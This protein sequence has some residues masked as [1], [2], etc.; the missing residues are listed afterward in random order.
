MLLLMEGFDTY[1]TGNWINKWSNQSGT[2]GAT[3]RNGTNGLRTTG[4][5]YLTHPLVANK[6]ELVVGFAFKISANKSWELV[7]F[8]DGS[9]VQLGVN[10]DAT[11]QILI[12]RHTATIKS[13]GYNVLLNTWYYIEFKGK[14]H[15]SLGEWEVHINGGYVDSGVGDTQQT[16]L[17]AATNVN[18]PFWAF[19]SG[20]A[21]IDDIYIF[22]T[23]G[24]VN[25]DFVGDVSVEAVF[26]DGVGYVTDWVGVPGGGANYDKV[27]ELD[28]DDDTTFVVTSGVGKMD[29]YDF[30]TLAALSGSVYAL[31]VNIW[32]RKDDVGDRQINAIV[33]PTS[34]TY[35][36]DVPKALGEA[37]GYFTFQFDT[38]P[39]TAGYWTIAQVNA[40]EFGI[41][42][43]V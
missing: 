20:T 27:D 2:I 37:Y 26:P 34:T 42:Q 3:G 23:E 17:A 21:D 41:K 24:S 1:G 22:D 14:I 7:Q 16:G 35:S 9:T 6:Q 15:Q 10:L 40:S 19:G 38:N 28:P 12:K 29:S 13:T 5:F 11:G 33:R 43:E 32:A 31:Q 18:I 8:R 39:Q 30:G 4:A 25:N 36:G